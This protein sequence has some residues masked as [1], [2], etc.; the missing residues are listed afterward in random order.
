MGK[1]RLLRS[2]PQPNPYSSGGQSGA[3]S[4]LITRLVPSADNATTSVAAVH[5]PTL[6][7]AKTA[8]SDPRRSAVTTFE[9][10]TR[11][12]TVTRT[13]APGR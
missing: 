9:T 4:R 8:L 13:D 10:R 2:F 12:D 11:A 7:A 6:I 1:E 5:R 3:G